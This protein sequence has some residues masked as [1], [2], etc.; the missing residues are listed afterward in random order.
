MERGCDFTV[1]APR[2]DYVPSDTLFSVGLRLRE[3]LKQLLSN[4]DRKYSFLKVLPLADPIQGGCALEIS[5]LGALK[6]RRPIVDVRCGIHTLDWTTTDVV[7]FLSWAKVNE[8]G[9]E[10][11]GRLRYPVSRIEDGKG[12]QFLKLMDFALRTLKPEMTIKEGFD[13]LM[14]RRKIRSFQVD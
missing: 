12:M 3:S 10:F 11:Y 14:A 9:N 2:A 6:I 7:Y 13:L 1:V 8:I 4:S 5:H